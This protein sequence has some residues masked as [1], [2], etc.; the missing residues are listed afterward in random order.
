[1]YCR[2]TTDDSTEHIAGL[3]KLRKY[4]ASYN[5]ISDRTPEILSGMRS[6]EEITFDSCAGLTNAGIATLARLP[7]LRELR[8]ESMPN[9]TADVVANFPA[10]VRVKYSA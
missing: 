10:R 2:E 3:A 4:F 8:V 1:M 6:L 7:R 5:R 9:V